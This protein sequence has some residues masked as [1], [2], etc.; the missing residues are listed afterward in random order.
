M[1]KILDSLS[2]G[3]VKYAAL[4]LHRASNVDAKET[5][6]R[7]FSVL[8]EIRG[9]SNLFSLAILVPEKNLQISN[10]PLELPPMES[11]F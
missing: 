7:V 2:L 1:S 5:L 10:F 9:E 4:S 11:I 6:Q 3:S 8:D